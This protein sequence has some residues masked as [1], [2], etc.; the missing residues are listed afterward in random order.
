[1][2]NYY[3]FAVAALLAW[4][5]AAGQKLPVNHFTVHDGLVQQQ[6]LGLFQ[7]SRG[8]IWAGTKSGISKFNGATF[9]NYFLEEGVPATNIFAFDEDKAGRLW[10]ASGAGLLVFDGQTWEYFPR[11]LRKNQPVACL[12][13]GSVLTIDA[14]GKI[15]LFKRGKYEFVVEGQ[16][17]IKDVSMSGFLPQP[18]LEG[19]LFFSDHNA[20]RYSEGQF[21]LAH[22]FD[23]TPYGVNY[24]GRLSFLEKRDSLTNVYGAD[25]RDTVLK[26]VP[27]RATRQLMTKSGDVYLGDWKQLV[28]ISKDGAPETLLSGVMVNALLEDRDGHIWIGT[29]N[30]IF[31]YFPHGFFY[32]GNEELPLPWGILQDEEY[33][34]WSPN[35]NHGLYAFEMGGPAE[36]VP[37]ELTDDE[38]DV[39]P[40]EGMYFSPSQDRDGHLYFAFSHGVIR[41]RDG[42]FDHYIK[43]ADYLL[44]EKESSAILGTYYDTVGQCL[45]AGATNGRLLLKKEE[46]PVKLIQVDSGAHAR[47]FV[48]SICHSP[49]GY[50]WWGSSAGLARMHIQTEEIDLYEKRAPQRGAISLSI[51]ADSVLWVGSKEGLMYYNAATDS[52]IAF[53]P[54][55]FQVWVMDITFTP[56]GL[57]LIAEQNEI[58]VV[59]WAHYKAT[60]QLRIKNYNYRYGFFG[61]ES[62]QSSCYLDREN[63][64]WVPA[65]NGAYF[66]DVDAISFDQPPAQVRIFRIN[67]SPIGFLSDEFIALPYG[68]NEATL[69]FEP[70]GFASTLRHQYS[71]RLLERDTNWSAWQEEPFAHFANLTSGDYTFEV[72]LRIAD[73]RHATVDVLHFSVSQPFY[74][75]PG[76][77]YQAAWAGLVLSG[78][79]MLL[80]IGIYR[81]FRKNQKAQLILREKEQQL[82]FYQVHTLQAQLNPHFINNTLTAMQH[83]SKQGDPDALDQ[84]IQRLAKLMGHFM[85]SSLSADLNSSVKADNTIRLTE[86]VELLTHYMEL[87]QVLHPGLF[88]FEIALPKA[89]PVSEISLPPM[90]LQPFVENA[91]EHGF[92]LGKNNGH[93]LLHFEME[94]QALYCRI[95]DDGIGRQAASELQASSM[96]SFKSRGTALVYERIRLLNNMGQ[97]IELDITDR[98]GGGTIVQLTIQ[99]NR[100]TAY[101]RRNY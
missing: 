61:L 72:R 30:G 58:K 86:E 99:T 8:Y 65:G 97:Y 98:P 84:Q 22:Q 23:G 60:G 54:D 101:D 37:I 67:G 93:L 56:N 16:S 3:L 82:T 71:Y 45:L 55:I 19:T 6:V 1:M 78:L 68:V 94:G 59:D 26:N 39:I 47:K 69:Q 15:L 5:D 100:T 48:V 33:R 50:Y 46:E 90:L 14:D 66:I 12:D 91:I 62:G 35:Y 63:R 79:L 2:K 80:S 32:Y 7:D 11:L 95:T 28:R 38:G 49:D 96:G 77:Y 42:V 75:A 51:A 92:R 89:V 81:Y 17:E 52:L 10:A 83:F 24:A 44:Q 85:E 21:H 41:Y 9:E 74:K 25:V 53:R 43:P 13:D 64:Y 40:T 88:T 27:L 20:W 18:T 36:K 76:F 31:Q 73:T 70:I 87:M 29:E 4:Y 57:M 34:Y